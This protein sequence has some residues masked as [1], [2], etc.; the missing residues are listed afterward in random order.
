MFYGLILSSEDKMK[1]I[2]FALFLGVCSSAFAS[3]EPSNGRV[4]SVAYECKFEGRCSDRNV[5]CRVEGTLCNE[6]DAANNGSGCRGSQDPVE[7][8]CSDGFRLDVRDSS[9]NVDNNTLWINAAE[10]KKI[11]TIRVEEIFG[12]R[13]GEVRRDAS[14][15]YSP[16]EGDAHRLEGSCRFSVRNSH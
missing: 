12:D 14:L 10:Y 3:T 16:S 9:V 6:F 8:K 13:R 1:K 2:I 7:I 5:E 11:A 4:E 15:L